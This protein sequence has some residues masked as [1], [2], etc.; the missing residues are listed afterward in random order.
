MKI[1]D[2]EPFCKAH[3][4][5]LYGDEGF[6][7]GPRDAD[8]TGVMFCWKPTL[9]AMQAAHDAGCNLIITHE[10]LNFPPVYS[11]ARVEEQLTGGV[12]LRRIHRLLAL[13]ITVFRIH[14]SLD[15]LCILDAFGEALGLGAPVIHGDYWE[16][17]YEIAPVTVRALAQQVKA[18]LNM[19]TVRVAGDLDRLVR[20][21]AL[22]WGGVAISANPNCV[23][24]LLRFDPDVLITGETEEVVMHAARDAGVPLIET[25]HSESES[26]GLRVFAA[27][28]TE[29]FPGV[30]TA[31]FQNPRPWALFPAGEGGAE[32]A[33]V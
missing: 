10:E 24:T 33:G 14:A 9:A 28:F 6:R 5:A 20:R 22:P 17:T 26:P 21:V 18:R 29:A 1:R 2:I 12:T 16:R 23:Q 4:L 32:R 31:F 25:G 7:F 30:R 8:L 11:G 19:D 15:R 27:L 3:D 13:G